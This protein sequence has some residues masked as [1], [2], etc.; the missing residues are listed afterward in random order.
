MKISNKILNPNSKFRR[1]INQFDLAGDF[2]VGKKRLYSLIDTFH[3]EYILNK[4]SVPKL[5]WEYVDNDVWYINNKFIS[6]GILMRN[7][8]SDKFEIDKL[9]DYWENIKRQL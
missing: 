2:V 4:E 5:Q 3:E 7:Q 8:D 9:K 6:L 1:K